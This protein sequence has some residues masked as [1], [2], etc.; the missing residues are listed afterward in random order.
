MNINAPVI[1]FLSS[2]SMQER[3]WIEFFKWLSI[4]YSSE[5]D[6]LKFNE[7]LENSSNSFEA[8]KIDNISAIAIPQEKIIRDLEKISEDWSQI[9]FVI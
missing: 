9:K 1:Q 5:F 3:H 4:P 8:D 6:S 2:S 7:I